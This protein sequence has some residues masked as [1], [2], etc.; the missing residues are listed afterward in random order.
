MIH[1]E[2]KLYNGYTG[3]MID[4]D[5]LAAKIADAIMRDTSIFEPS[6]YDDHD[7]TVENSLFIPKVFFRAYFSD[8]E[9]SL[10]DAI[11][12]QILLSIGA[13]DILEC[14]FGYSEWTIEGYDVENF[15]LIS[16]NGTGHD[17]QQIF[18][19]YI[20]KYVHILIDILE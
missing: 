19:N 13:L 2:G 12:N 17:L 5:T 8:R 20:G 9:C 7:I 18:T 10:L 4:G 16:E 14:W 1:I 3:L 11:N 6:K 15:K